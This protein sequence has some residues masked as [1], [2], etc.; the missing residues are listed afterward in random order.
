MGLF[1]RLRKKE[2]PETPENS[3]L[4]DSLGVP[5]TLLPGNVTN[6]ALMQY[7][8]NARE[9][10]RKEGFTPLLVK[11]EDTLEDCLDVLEEGY[12]LE[13]ARRKAQALDGKTILAERLQ[14]LTELEDAECEPF[15]MDADFLG[16]LEN[17]EESHDFSL[18]DFRPARIALVQL[19]TEKPWEAVLYL[20]FGGW[21]E[22]PKPEE[23][24]A[25]LRYWHER[26][27]AVPAAITFD[28]LELVLPAPVP[29]DAAWD[30]A[31]E[32]F[33]YTED[34]VLQG[35]GTLGRLADGLWRSDVWFFWWD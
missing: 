6:E 26:W 14:V 17:G 15:V 5:Y 32:H 35:T 24:A 31:K 16:T 33:A 23:H 1:D 11:L 28:T 10:G 21:N 25:I 13:E 20:P 19:P 7:Y 2:A 4:L 18:L 27:G 29:K 22:C 34:C 9:Q 30:V 12:S 3:P 8:W